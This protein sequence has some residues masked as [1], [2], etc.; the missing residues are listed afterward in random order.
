[1]LRKSSGIRSL[2]CS[3]LLG[4]INIV[5]KHGLFLFGAHNHKVIIEGI[6]IFFLCHFTKVK[7]LNVSSDLRRSAFYRSRSIFEF[8]G[9]FSATIQRQQSF[10]VQRSSLVMIDELKKHG[11]FI[12]Q[13]QSTALRTAQA[14][15]QC[16]KTKVVELKFRWFLLV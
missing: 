7:G 11:D 4:K 15:V 14:G 13:K 12:I 3:V 5:I 9:P 1:M 16:F 6:N 8:S 2:K 10:P